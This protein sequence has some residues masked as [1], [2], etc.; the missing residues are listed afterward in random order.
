[1]TQQRKEIKFQING[2]YHI[3]TLHGEIQGNML[4]MDITENNETGYS[5]IW[6]REVEGGD[7][8][9]SAPSLYTKSGCDDILVGNTFYQTDVVTS[10]RL[11]QDPKTT[12]EKRKAEIQK[13]RRERL[14][15]IR[16]R[17]KSKRIEGS[18]L[19]PDCKDDKN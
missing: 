2:I 15:S 8:V 13:K 19:P 3:E 7:A 9:M 5:T 16:E 6:L 10:V 1:M 4:V 17:V 11:V 12:L 14:A 18:D